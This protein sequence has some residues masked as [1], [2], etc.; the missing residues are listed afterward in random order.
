MWF[1]LQ[2]VQGKAMKC[3]SDYCHQILSF[4]LQKKDCDGRYTVQTIVDRHPVPHTLI[5]R[6]LGLASY[7]R[8]LQCG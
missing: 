4:V 8:G 7:L 3:V 2:R 1:K 6:A 5:L